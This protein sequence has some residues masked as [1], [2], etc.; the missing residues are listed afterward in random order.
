VIVLAYLVCAELAKHWG[1]RATGARAMKN[2]VKR[3]I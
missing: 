3:R 2:Q 1:D